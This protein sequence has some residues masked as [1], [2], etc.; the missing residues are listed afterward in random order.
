M[1]KNICILCGK[2]AVNKGICMADESLNQ[3]GKMSYC[4]SYIKKRLDKSKPLVSSPFKV[5]SH[6]Q[7]TKRV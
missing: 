1:T 5:L 3:D 2:S 7:I 6:F 4:P